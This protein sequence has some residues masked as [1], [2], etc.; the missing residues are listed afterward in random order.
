[1]TLM[2]DSSNGDSASPP[3]LVSRA[4]AGMAAGGVVE[5]AAQ[6]PQPFGGDGFGDVAGPDA[7][8]DFVAV[9]GAGDGDVEPPPSALLV[10]RA[11]VHGDLPVLVRPVADGEDQHVP[12]VALHGFEALDEEPAQPVV[13]EEPVQVGAVLPGLADRG[14]DRLGLGL[15]EG[16]HTE[17][18]GGPGVVVVNHPFS[19]RGGLLRVIPGAS[20]PV[21]P[22]HPEQLHADVGP[23][24]VPAGE[25]DEPSFV[26]RGVGE[27]DERLVQG[28]VVPA[29][30][31]APV[32]AGCLG[33][34][35]DRLELRGVVG[36]FGPFL[37]V[38]SGGAGE[39]VARRQLLLVSGQDQGR[40]A[41]DAVDGI[42]GA[43]LAGLVEDDDVEVQV[44]WQ[45]LADRERGHHEAWL[46]RLRDVAGPFDQGPH[47]HVLL[48]FLRF[49]A[50]DGGLADVAAGAPRVAG[51][52]D[53]ARGRRDECPVQL[54][55][56]ADQRV[57]VG[58]AH[59]GQV[60]VG[61]EVM[62]RPFLQQGPFDHLGHLPG[63]HPFGNAEVDGDAEAVRGQRRAAGLVNVPFVLPAGVLAKGCDEISA[64]RS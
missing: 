18:E 41:V 1:M 58:R 56:F 17:A 30:R 57:P 3:E 46:D 13:G 6:V 43:D 35:E 37:F 54:P 48:L 21:G 7:A 28:P 40:A 60:R 27:R 36:V 50:D 25:G 53:A 8:D 15:A 34:V 32:G 33:V 14:L 47:R 49:A 10:E 39:E 55:V 51:A 64:R 20:P 44:R 16:D 42:A 63:R 38:V 11:E 5:V 2:T 62:L 12:L 52:D 31:Q 29:Q 24:A 61:P 23:V 19:D 26:E 4:R 45:V 9:A 59:R 22:V